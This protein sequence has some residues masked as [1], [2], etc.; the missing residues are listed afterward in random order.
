[1]NRKLNPSQNTKNIDTKT[2]LENKCHVSTVQARTLR[3]NKAPWNVFICA[4]EPHSSLFVESSTFPLLSAACSELLSKCPSVF[5]A[6][7]RFCN[8][9][10]SSDLATKYVCPGVTFLSLWVPHS[11]SSSSQLFFTLSS[12]LL[13]G[14]Y[15]PDRQIMGV[16]STLQLRAVIHTNFFLHNHRYW[17]SPLILLTTTILSSKPSS[18]ERT[19]CTST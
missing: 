15:R 14:F 10:S 16:V 1:M 12:S 19:N 4:S 18:S 8:T 3:A 9:T 13:W 5:F 2:D 6:P 11:S 17:Q 7:H